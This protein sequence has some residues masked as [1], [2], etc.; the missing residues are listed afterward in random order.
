MSPIAKETWFNR[1]EL[2]HSQPEN[3][4]Q[5]RSLSAITS[6]QPSL[7]SSTSPTYAF[8]ASREFS[9]FPYAPTI[10]SS[11][12][13][14]VIASLGR[15]ALFRL[16]RVNVWGPKAGG[17]E[18][19]LESEELE[20]AKLTGYRLGSEVVEEIVG[21]GRAKS[22]HGLL[23]KQRNEV[24]QAWVPEGE[25]RHSALLRYVA[26]CHCSLPCMLFLRF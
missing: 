7:S 21:G 4:T 11:L 18:I 1:A 3:M 26:V 24:D 10:G 19:D 14:N 6:P 25:K 5:T 9:F 22:L 16:R 15:R 8:N 20:N 17:R 13:W 23:R 12:P 2:T